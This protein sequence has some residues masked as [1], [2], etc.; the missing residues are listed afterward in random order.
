MDPQPPQLPPPQKRKLPPAVSIV[1]ALIGAFF[2]MTVFRHCAN[3]APS[4][5][6][7]IVATSSQLNKTL[8][9]MVDSE[10]RLDN[11]MAA[12]DKTIIYRYTLINMNAADIKKDQLV[13]AIRPQVVATYKTNDTMKEFRNNGITMQYQYSDKSGVFITQFS[14]GPKDL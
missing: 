2:G 3:Q 10:T 7:A 9:M 5:D 11:T 8:P 6:Q 1:A 4:I 14:V 13:T 12:P